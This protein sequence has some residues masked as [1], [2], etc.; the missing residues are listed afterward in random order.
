MA[1]LPT[2]TITL[3][4]TDIEGST[5]LLHALGDRYPDVL[6]RYRTLVRTIVT[7]WA[8]HEVDLQGDGCFMVFPRVGDAVQAA[9][10]IQR[11]V[12]AQPWP[13]ARA[14]RTRIG[15][16]TG[17][18]RLNDG[19]Y[20]G[21]D[22]HRAARIAAAGHG[23]QILLSQATASLVRDHLPAEVTLRELGEHA[24]KDLPQ[25]ERLFQ[26]VAP[27]L[28]AEFPPLRIR[29]HPPASAKPRWSANGSPGAGGWLPGCR[30]TRGIA[31][32]RAF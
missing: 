31:I 32:P 6:A 27:E 23:G 14:P 7:Q 12:A 9:L 18:P 15:L 5:R 4:F 10:A 24:L 25:R 22:V 29:D 26:L 16:H 2:G 11:A 13:E 20:V 30:W 17:A 21:L 1:A 8:G 3:C 19:G 28:A